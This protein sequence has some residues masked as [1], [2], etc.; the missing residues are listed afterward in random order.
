MGLTIHRHASGEYYNAV[1]KFRDGLLEHFRPLYPSYSRDVING[2][3]RDRNVAF[4]VYSPPIGG[5]R[6]YYPI[7]HPSQGAEWIWSFSG[8]PEVSVT[9]QSEAF[10][11]TRWTTAGTP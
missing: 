9:V 8:S 5:L 11:R 1:E 7:P 3:L 4:A 2:W 6:H 10:M